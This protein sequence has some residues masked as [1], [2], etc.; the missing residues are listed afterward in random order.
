MIRPFGLSEEEVRKFL[1]HTSNLFPA[2]RYPVDTDPENLPEERDRLTIRVLTLLFLRVVAYMLRAVVPFRR[3]DGAEDTDTWYLLL[4]RTAPRQDMRILAK[5]LYHKAKAYLRVKRLLFQ[6][7]RVF[8][9]DLTFISRLSL[10]A[11]RS[12]R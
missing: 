2:V 9:P 5:F 10:T 7:I 6:V 11:R 1:L 12:I 8:L 3:Q 4:I